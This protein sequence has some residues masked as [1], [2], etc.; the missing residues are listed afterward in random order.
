MSSSLLNGRLGAVCLLAVASLHAAAPEVALS[1]PEVQKLDWNTR[2]L[3]AV[4]MNGDKL[5]DVLVAN[6]DRS[7]IDILYQLKPG[8]AREVATKSANANRWEPVVEDARFRRERVTTGVT[9]YDLVAGDLNG[10]G[11]ADLA[12]SGDP[13][14]LTVRYQEEEG[15]WRE[16]KLSEAPGPIQSPG[17]LRLADL[18]G[19]GRTDLV[20]LGLKELVVFYQSE[21]GELASPQRFPLA[22]ENC[23]GLELFDVDGDGRPDIVYLSNSPRDAFRVRLQNAQAQFGPEQAYSI[24][25]ARSTLQVLAP[26]DAKAKQPARLVF[27]QQRTGQLEFFNL[28]TAKKGKDGAAPVLRP[29][30]FTPRTSGKTPA[31]YAFGDFNADGREDIAVSDADGAQVFIYFRQADGGF[32]TAER[33]PSFADVRSLAAGDWTGDGRADLIVASLKE[34]SVGVA[35]VNAEGRLDYPQPLPGTGRP[36]AVA[37]GDVMGKG[38]LSIV[39]LREEKGKRWFDVLARNSEGA[40]VILRTVELTGLKTDPRGLRLIDANQDGRLDVAVFTPLDSMRLFLQNADGSFTD[41]SAGAGFRKGLVDNLDASAVSSGDP[42]GDGKQA[43]LVST[44]GF[45]RALSLDAKGALTVIDQFNARDT[46]AEITASF[47]I[48]TPKGGRSEVLL[49]DRKGEQFQRLRANKQGVYEVVDAVPVGRIDVV[50]AEVRATGKGG[51]QSELFLLGKDRFWW[52]PLDRG[53]FTARSVETYTT[54][55]PEIN[56]SDVIAGDLTDDGKVELVTL[57]PDN[58]VVEVLARDESSKAWVSRV[59]FKVFETDD[60][61]QGRRG[62]ALEPRE[63]IVADVTGDGKKDLLLLVHDRVLIY[64]QK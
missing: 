27:A 57:D 1:G 26:A 56:Y 62:E 19:D 46:T 47:V 59:H 60:H 42:A 16:V 55:L 36:L 52:M 54:D 4:D 29:R 8:E 10:D 18:N 50:G 38:K 64:P 30:V 7:T 32:T 21:A 15:T 5:L 61:Y 48:P 41:A 11:R 39:V 44:G 63:A 12:Y 45:T 23:Y 13:Q 24:K 35:S 22:D 53:D 40:P 49:Y 51:R 20:M 34:Q 6:N 25:S 33:F 17:S 14:A 28:E 9:M 37:A 2:V 58:S 3:Q 43:L 31:S